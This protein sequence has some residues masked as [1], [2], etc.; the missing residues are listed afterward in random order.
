MQ[1][2]KVK[3]CLSW[4]IFLPYI[5]EAF[6]P[7][8]QFLALVNVILRLQFFNWNTQMENDRINHCNFNQQ[9]F[10]RCMKWYIVNVGKIWWKA[11]WKA[12]CI[13]LQSETDLNHCNPNQQHSSVAWNGILSMW[14]KFEHNFVFPKHSSCQMYVIYLCYTNNKPWSDLERL[15]RSYAIFPWIKYE[16]VSISNSIN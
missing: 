7:W 4:E 6:Y 2:K 3:T 14:V 16:V 8:F 9:Q 10:F 13:S 12:W 5:I 15:I 1:K 11:Q